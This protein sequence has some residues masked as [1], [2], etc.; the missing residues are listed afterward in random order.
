MVVRINKQLIEYLNLGIVTA[1]M[2][3]VVYLSYLTAKLL[4][5]AI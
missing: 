5:Q 1:I 4:Y 2:T 3:Y